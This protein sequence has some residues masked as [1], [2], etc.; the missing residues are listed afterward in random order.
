MASILN[1]SKEI[2][3]KKQALSF[4]CFLILASGCKK[5]GVSAGSDDSLPLAVNEPVSDYSPKLNLPAPQIAAIPFEGSHQ[6][7]DIRGVGDSA[8]SGLRAATAPSSEFGATLKKFDPTGKIL[9]GD[10]NFINWES[11]VGRTCKSYFNVDYAFLSDP[12]A[13]LEAH[14]HG[15]NLFGLANNHSEDCRTGVD[16]QMNSVPGAV[17]TQRHMQQISNSSELAWHGV[18]STRAELVKPAQIELSVK[19]RVLKVAFVSVAF[20]SWDCV[21]ST[22]EANVQTLFDNVRNT[23]AD[24]RILSLHSQGR[25]GFERGK[26]WAEK[27]VTQYSGDIVFAHGPHTWAGVKA[28]QKKDGSLGIVFHGLGNFL[29]NQVA[30]NPDNLI[31]R[32]L[33]DLTTL[34][35]AQ[36]QVI[37]VLNNAYNVDVVLAPSSKPFPL[38]NFK[39]ERAELSAHTKVN[40]GYAQLP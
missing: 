28:L 20:Q 18:G 35:P 1:D 24:L 14:R 29:H 8:W 12:A 17:S 26:V 22:C 16:P 36:V 3:F 23:A 21:E 11:G 2:Q 6:F 34:K 15:F 38:A 33:L 37:P 13:V 5:F 39:W 31:G 4:M 7:L 32:V 27:F 25:A 9:R 30:P 10:L 40:I 19:G